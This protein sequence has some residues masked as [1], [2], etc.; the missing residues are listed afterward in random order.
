LVISFIK[1]LFTWKEKEERAKTEINIEVLQQEISQ[2]RQKE[3]DNFPLQ[4]TFK[5]ADLI[6][7]Q[8]HRFKT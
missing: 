4:T 1:E 6:P 8:S 3:E 7:A 5:R 2:N